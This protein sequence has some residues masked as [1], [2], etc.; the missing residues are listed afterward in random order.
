MYKVSETRLTRSAIGG[1]ILA[2][3]ASGSL[4]APAMAGPGTGSS[5]AGAVTAASG[6][7]PVAPTGRQAEV[8]KPG[9][10]T[11]ATLSARDAAL[12][13]RQDAL[14]PTARDLATQSGVAGSDIAGVRLE[15][16]ADTVHVYRTDTGRDLR[17]S[18]SVPAGVKV[19][20]HPAKFSRNAMLQAV[21]SVTGDAKLLGEQNV[22]VQAVGP[23]V[24]G[25][26]VEISVVAANAGEVDKATAA[27]TKRY[28]AV[29]G[30]V[31]G[32]ERRTSEKDL[33][34]GGWRFNDYAP[35]YG[36]D[37]IASSSGGCSTGF[38]ALLNNA[39]VMLTAAHC[40]GVG[41]AF[42]NG[43]R[44][45]GTFSFMGSSVYSNGSTDVGALSV[46][47][48][49]S[50]I[51]VGPAEFSSQL[52]VP[53][54]GSP[55]VGQYLCQSGSYTGETCGLYVVDTYQSVCI[56]WFLWWCTGWQGP[57]SDVVTIYGS[58]S[59]AAGHGDSGG[60]VYAYNGSS[61]IATGLVHGQLTPNAAAAYPAYFPDTLWCP[62]PEGWSQRCSSGFSFAHMPGY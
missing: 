49:S 15:V 56:S 58:G 48:G 7:H 12:V 53:S 14:L 41:T 29:I 31:T 5:T 38:S 44:T 23:T 6:A 27:L 2:L 28:G 25:S 17:L 11:A 16:E 36:G 26:G 33:F 62:A 4:G 47:S 19:V 51:N 32:T 10:R 42:Y 24:D 8:S 50:Y 1:V 39:P 18:A 37:R 30:K 20:V 45:D 59:Y 21:A 34:F 13:K 22:S 61:G 35:W 9:Q 57:L 52:Y 60:P 3:V 54:W 55:F 43:P 46:T 40:G